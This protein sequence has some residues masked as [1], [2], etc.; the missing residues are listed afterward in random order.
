LPTPTP[1][2][3]PVPTPTPGPASLEELS[4]TY[5]TETFTGGSIFVNLTI[6]NNGGLTSKP[7]QIYFDQIDKYADLNGCV[8]I[9]TYS[10]FLGIR[11]TF[12]GGIAGGQTVTYKVE[13]IATKVGVADWGLTVYEGDASGDLIFM[14]TAK[15]VIR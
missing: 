13:F 2:P 8:P 3:T 14:G 11:V 10:D 9:C 6:K 4:T 5:T 15:T 12:E 1:V 7:V